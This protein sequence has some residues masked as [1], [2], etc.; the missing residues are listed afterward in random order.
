MFFL[1]ASSYI[2]NFKNKYIRLEFNGNIQFSSNK[3]GYKNAEKERTL[4]KIYKAIWKDN[5]IIFLYIKYSIFQGMIVP[6]NN[7]SIVDSW[8]WINLLIF[9]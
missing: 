8:I 6:L 3:S 7:M 9:H 1:Y 5:K 4:E 2:N